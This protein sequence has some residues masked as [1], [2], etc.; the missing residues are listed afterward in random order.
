LTQYIKKIKNR[1]RKK[2]EIKSDKKK[3]KKKESINE[4]NKEKLLY[5]IYDDSVKEIILSNESD[6]EF[7]NICD[8]KNKNYNIEKDEYE[9]INIETDN[10]FDFLSEINLKLNQ[11]YDHNLYEACKCQVNGIIDQRIQSL[12]IT[13]DKIK[14][15]LSLIGPLNNEE[16]PLRFLNEKEKYEYHWKP[17][18]EYL[19]ENFM[20]LKEKIDPNNTFLHEKYQ[21]IIIA[22]TPPIFVAGEL[23][24]KTLNIESK[25]ILLK[26]SKI[27]NEISISENSMKL[28]DYKCLSDILY[29]YSQTKV[30]FTTNKNINGCFY[31][32]NIQIL[33]RDV[34]NSC[35]PLEFSNSPLDTVIAEGEKR[36]RK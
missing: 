28:L 34:D 29:L 32:E 35:V 7:I 17:M 1:N 27:L 5:N 4:D 10:S 3:S 6:I 9:I 25:E 16:P 13:L 30:L 26:I 24:Y 33:K 19:R 18:K 22:L 23:N 2:K 11:D 21:K 14:H 8:K 15:V 31:G 36:I 12:A 20:K